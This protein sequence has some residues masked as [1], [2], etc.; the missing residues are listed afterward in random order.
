MMWEAGL[1]C[2]PSPLKLSMKLSSFD[3]G[4]SGTSQDAVLLGAVII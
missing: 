1:M 3:E 4:Q 2:E